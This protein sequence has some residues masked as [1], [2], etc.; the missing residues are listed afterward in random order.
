[1]S[2][3]NS[4]LKNTTQKAVTVLVGVLL[5]TVSLWNESQTS[6]I[7]NWFKL[8]SSIVQEIEQ[9]Y[10]GG[11]LTGV[12]KAEL[13]SDTV[14][15]I[16]QLMWNK[17]TFEKTVEEIDSLR[18]GPLKMLCVIMDNPEILKASTTFL[19]QLLK[20]LDTNNDG[21]ISVEECCFC[22]PLQ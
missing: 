9:R 11:V 22:I 3:L 20:A 13:A 7:Q 1:M 2:E 17:F 18:K 6:N 4:S 8:M 10:G 21:E 15:K 5:P 12:Q 14:S 19:K 16:A